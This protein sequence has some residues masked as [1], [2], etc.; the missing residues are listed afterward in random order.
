MATQVYSRIP[1]HPC[2]TTELDLENVPPTQVVITDDYVVSTGPS[3]HWI[4]KD[5]WNSNSRPT[6]TKTWTSASVT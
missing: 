1:C 6:A 2:S 4:L 5:L 3:R